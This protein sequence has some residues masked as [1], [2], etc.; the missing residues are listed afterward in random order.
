MNSRL[1]N[2]DEL[3]YEGLKFEKDVI[4]RYS[5]DDYRRS[6]EVLERFKK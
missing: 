5:G 1:F 6:S 4:N 2:K 3:G